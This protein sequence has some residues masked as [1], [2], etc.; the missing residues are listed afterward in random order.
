M[1]RGPPGLLVLWKNGSLVGTRVSAEGGF[2]IILPPHTPPIA[3]PPNNSLHVLCVLLRRM[4]QLI[5]I[6][7]CVRQYSRFS[8]S[9]KEPSVQKAGI[10]VSP[11]IIHLFHSKGLLYLSAPSVCFFSTGL[12]HSV[13]IAMLATHKPQAALECDWCLS[14]FPWPEQKWGEWTHA[15][16]WSG[17]S[18]RKFIIANKFFF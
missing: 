15:V 6:P 18:C 8:D 1:T 17:S 2:W 14:S 3:P 7:S 11:G 12:H 9:C 16:A 4:A 13:V 5:K 10:R